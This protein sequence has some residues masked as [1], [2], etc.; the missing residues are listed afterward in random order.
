MN[1]YPLSDNTVVEVAQRKLM[2]A[3]SHMKSV[4]CSEDV[5][6]IF[7]IQIS[8]I[9]DCMMQYKGHHASVSQL[10]KYVDYLADTGV[11]DISQVISVLKQ[12]Y[13]FLVTSDEFSEFKAQAKTLPNF[14]SLRI[15]I[16]LAYVAFKDFSITEGEVFRRVGS[17]IIFPTRGSFSNSELLKTAL[18][19]WLENEERVKTFKPHIISSKVVAALK[20]IINAWFS[21]FSFRKYP[22]TPHFS[23]GATFECS[24]RGC[25]HHVANKYSKFV[26]NKKHYAAMVVMLEQEAISETMFN[27]LLKLS[28]DN[29]RRMSRRKCVDKQGLETTELDLF[30]QDHFGRLE[31]QHDTQSYLCDM[32]SCSRLIFVPK[33]ATTVRTVSAESTAGLYLQHGVRESI[34][35]YLLDNPFFKQRMDITDQSINQKAALQGSL[36]GEKSPATYDLSKASDSIS[37]VLVSILF[38]DMPIGLILEFLRNDCVVLPNEEKHY[39]NSFSPMGAP[40]TFIIQTIIYGAFCQLSCEIAAGKDFSEVRPFYPHP[41]SVYGDDIIIPSDCGQLLSE[42]LE[43]NGWLVNEE[44]SFSGKSSY[45]ESCGIEAKSGYEITSLKVSRKLFYPSYKGNAK[46]TGKRKRKQ[47]D[48]KNWLVSKRRLIGL[49]NELFAYGM[50]ETRRW[51]LKLLKKQKYEKIIFGYDNPDCVVSDFA[52]NYHVRWRFSRYHTF[53]TRQLVLKESSSYSKREQRR[54][55]Y[56]LMKY[57]MWLERLQ[58]QTSDESSP[59]WIDLIEG[60]AE[61]IYDNCYDYSDPSDVQKNC[62]SRIGS[63]WIQGESVV[64]EFLRHDKPIE[65]FCRQIKEI[66]P[67]SLVNPIIG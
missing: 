29:I 58:V 56:Q 67:S 19:D 41:W 64:G 37:N 53:C 18:G 51:I 62:S 2:D 21:D 11:T 32:E 57:I 31:T 63:Y 36:A 10:T 6:F 34:L 35:R 48:V 22:A 26:L 38:G 27:T 9:Y 13:Q 30:I 25:K 49:A 59:R 40:L 3:F 42:F 12:L 24:R 44:K 1:P 23:S 54:R 45:R 20:T 55:S 14:D 65:G 52:T 47:Q 28:S 16:E 17:C 60:Q 7:Q 61:A 39:L 66:C 43:S 33:N 4:D 46:N 8:M 50:W 5:S 15:F